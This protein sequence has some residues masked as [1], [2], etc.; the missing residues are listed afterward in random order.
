MDLSRDT[1]H[2]VA[3]PLET[4]ATVAGARAAHASL[5]GDLDGLDDATVARPSRLPGWTVGH[6]LTHLAR[7]ADAHVRMLEGAAAGEITDQ[8]E[9]GVA[10]RSAEIEAGAG[11]PAADQ[12]ADLAEAIARLERAWDTTTDVV[13]AQG[14]GRGPRGDLLACADLP[15]RRWREV[16]VHHADLGLGFGPHDWDAAYVDTELPRSLAALPA[17]L[18]LDERRALLAW[19]MGRADGPPPLPPW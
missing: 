17:R 6:V 9:G 5:L 16:A 19:L 12:V 13:W 10:G 18:G 7:N 3:P 1:E 8:Y 15:F 11:R 2:L 4:A 14:F